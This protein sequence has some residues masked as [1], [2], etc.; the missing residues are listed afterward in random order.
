MAERAWTPVNLQKFGASL[1]FMDR[2][3][4]KTVSES[5]TTLAQIMTPNDA[6]ILGKVF[7]GSI[8]AMI[9]L[10]ASA[11]A[12]KY[13]GY[14]S[15]TAAFDR[16]DFHTPVEI[17]ELV[18]MEGYV[19]YAGRTSMEITIEIYASNLTKG[20]KH[21]TNTAR[22]TMVALDEGKPALVPR[23]VCESKEDKVRY[24]VAQ[25]RRKSRRAHLEDIEKIIE[26]FNAS[27]DEQL[28]L[29]ISDSLIK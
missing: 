4:T 25:T 3:L 13:S 1:N 23:L 7:G 19:S 9:D 18:T 26:K 28:D 24:L 15:V 16:V 6:N 14:I 27:T 29:L 10:T 21:H 11:T 17:G 22:V 12:Q 20:E 5:R 2:T 8:L